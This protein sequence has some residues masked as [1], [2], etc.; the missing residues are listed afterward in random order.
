MIR[1]TVVNAMYRLM[2]TTRKK[3]RAVCLSLSSL[4]PT[5]R[6]FSSRHTILLQRPKALAKNSC[7]RR[8]GNPTAVCG[9]LQDSGAPWQWSLRTGK[10]CVHSFTFLSMFP[11]QLQFDMA[12]LQICWF[13]SFKWLGMFAKVRA[14]NK[15]DLLHAGVQGLL[16]ARKG[17]RTENCGPK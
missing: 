11:T 12:A 8:H 13:V 4:R 9:R 14:L 16:S 5:L 1:C 2:Q 6:T 15:S 7:T 3:R 17:V 10:R